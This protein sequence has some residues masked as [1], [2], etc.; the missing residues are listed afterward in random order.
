MIIRLL[1]VICMGLSL[2]VPARADAEGNPVVLVLGDSLSA[3]YGIALEQGW[4]ALLQA[5]IES[6]GLP[7]RV[8]NASI[9]GDT[10]DGGLT[11]LPG[12]LARN[13][14]ALI[15]VELGAND[16]LRGFA[17]T[18][19]ERNLV[20]LVRQAQAADANV[21][22]AGVRLPPNYGA[23]YTEAFQ[24]IFAAVAEQTDAALVPRL[25]EGISEDRSLMQADEIHPTAAAQPKILDN[26]WPVLFPL[27][28][29]TANRES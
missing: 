9:S 27:L 10:T 7:H 15:I 2:I 23:A 16:G 24:R 19:I 13:Q 5:R 8:V 18:Q 12:L 25:L 3:G 22:V 26:L 1:A 28:E 4:V 11:R 6:Q 29:Q 20:D 14:P 21:V 17:P